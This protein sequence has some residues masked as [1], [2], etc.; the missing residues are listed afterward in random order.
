MPISKWDFAEMAEYGE[1]F[2]GAGDRKIALNFALAKGA[3][4]DPEVLLHHFDPH[5]YLIKITPLNPTYSARENALSSY[6]D[7]GAN[8]R[9]YQIIEDLQSA[10]YKVILSIGETEENLIGSNCGQY[11]A[12]HQRQKERMDK[13]YTYELSNI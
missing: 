12:E 3:P 9:K 5:K 1:R 8:G 6:I 7:T 11:I 4:V 2:Y 10:G 13:G